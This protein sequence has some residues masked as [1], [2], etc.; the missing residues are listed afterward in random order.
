[1]GDGGPRAVGH[2]AGSLAV[3]VPADLVTTAEREKPLLAFVDLEP[4]VEKTCEAIAH[5]R[6]NP[7]TAHV[8][9][10]AFATAQNTDAQDMARKRG[11][12]LVVPDNVLLQHLN[13][14]MD[15]ALT[16]E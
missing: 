11:A 14:F 8:P 15:Q 1:M 5:L 16:I 12:T 9:V 6:Q 13:Q 4:R 2:V 3:P 7:A 10:I